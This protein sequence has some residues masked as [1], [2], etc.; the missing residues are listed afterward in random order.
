MCKC[1]AEMKLERGVEVEDGKMVSEY[2]YW[3][4]PECE[5]DYE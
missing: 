5:C 2:F 4:C 3:Y 1:G